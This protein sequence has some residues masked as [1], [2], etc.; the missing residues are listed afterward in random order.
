MKPRI[1]VSSTFYDLKYI[2]E[3]LANYIKAH[4]FEPI[5]F[6]DGD[7]GYNPLTSLDD[8]C[9]KSMENADMALLIIGGNYGS[10]AT[11]E[12]PDGFQEFV[13]ITRREFQ[14]GVEEGVPFFVF[15]D[16]NVFAEY[17][18]YDL[19]SK[20]I[21]SGECQVKFK[22]TK[23]I[24]VFRF[25]REIR[26][27]KQISI[28][29]FDKVS[30]I[31]DFLSKQ[32]AD[33]FKTYLA[34]IKEQKEIEQLRDTVN[35]MNVLMEKMDKILDAVGKEVLKDSKAEYQQIVEETEKAEAKTVCLLIAKY[36]KIDVDKGK[37]PKRRDHVMAFLTALNEMYEQQVELSTEHDTAPEDVSVEDANIVVDAFS[38]TL[39]SSGMNIN[40]IRFLIHEEI[41]KIHPYLQDPDKMKEV[42]ALLCSG[43]YY[44][45]VFRVINSTL[46]E[47]NKNG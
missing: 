36:V 6:E 21:D 34:S 47:S 3:D 11:G 7:I 22:A 14:K 30:D 41:N 4:D 35:N 1:F 32:W 39:K 24:N 31:K 29:E 13:S 5:L 43:P 18:I 46:E 12:T 20:E 45:R 10:P 8:S 38:Q 28:T 2:R 26:S 16:R 25:I 44:Y 9:Y 42:Y 37:N 40:T 19:N 15:V 17:G 33:M 23:H 27:I